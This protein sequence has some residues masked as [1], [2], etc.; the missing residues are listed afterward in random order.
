MIITLLST[1]KNIQKGFGNC[2]VE[3]K[4]RLSVVTISIAAGSIR[5]LVKFFPSWNTYLLPVGEKHRTNSSSRVL[6]STLKH[7]ERETRQMH[8]SA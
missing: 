8:L 3:H 7:G 6:L 1:V 5:K 4:Q 2:C